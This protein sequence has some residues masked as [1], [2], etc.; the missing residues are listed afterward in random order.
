[1][2]QYYI[3]TENSVKLTR[4]FLNATQYYV[5]T[6]DILSNLTRYCVLTESYI[7]HI[8]HS[9]DVQYNIHYIYIITMAMLKLAD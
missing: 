2:A 8:G 4:H 6:Q 3:V 7:R 1:M 9:V 5:R